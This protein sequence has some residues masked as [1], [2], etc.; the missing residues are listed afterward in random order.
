MTNPLPTLKRLGVPLL[1]WCF[2][3]MPL[4]A[5]TPAPTPAPVMESPVVWTP[6]PGFDPEAKDL[7]LAGL[8]GTR[9]VTIYD[10]K[11]NTPIRTFGTQPAAQGW[12]NHHANILRLDNH[13]VVTWT[14]HLSDENGPGQRLL[15][16]TALI[17]KDGELQWSPNIIELAPPPVAMKRR[18]WDSSPD[19]IDA[20]YLVGRLFIIKGRLYFKGSLRAY[21]GWSD[22][23]RYHGDWKRPVPAQHYRSSATP[24]DKFKY[25]IR[26]D[27]KMRCIQAWE[28]RGADL[29]PSSPMYLISPPVKSIEVTPGVSKPV[30]PLDKIYAGAASITKA[31]TEIQQAV[32]AEP[33]VSFERSPAYGPN[34]PGHIA[35]DGHNGLAHSA[36][37]QRPDGQWVVL[38]DNLVNRG[39]YYA[40]L[41]PDAAVYYPPAVRTN[42]FGD[43]DPE[44]G[45]LPDGRVWI[46]GNDQ[47]RI[48]LYMTLSD[49]GIHFN[50][51]WLLYRARLPIKPGLGKAG[52]PNGPQYPKALLVGKQLVVVYSIGKQNI[53][54]S[55]VPLD[56]FGIGEKSISTA[57][58]Q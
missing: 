51:T 15:A 42:L 6:P 45:E 28:F 56:A 48:H 31:S 41:K 37:F 10:P 16:R 38:R 12:L 13:L 43:V 58:H 7:G 35:A 25:D 26:R 1:A 14:S 9:H 24:R 5:A 27:L 29:V 40:S 52:Y 21:D 22:V 19:K 33:D 44:A 34:T 49:D 55:M 30:I 46:I 17:G 47:K 3:A 53:G 8:P 50:K 39:F 4:N 20:P 54:V 23:V 57:K 11:S 36:E 32:N 2:A 18:T